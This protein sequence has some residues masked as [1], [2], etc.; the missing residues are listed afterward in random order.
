MI[1]R[2]DRFVWYELATTDR[3]AAKAFYCQVMDWGSCEM[4]VPISYTLFTVEEVPVCGLMDLSMS[5][6]EKGAKPRWLGFIGV[7]DVDASVD[8]IRRLGGSVLVPPTEVVNQ[9]HFAVVADPQM[10]NFA[11]VAWPKRQQ[12]EAGPRAQ[13]R[14]VWHE[15]LAGDSEK[16]L[17]FY[18]KLFGWQRAEARA[19]PRAVLSWTRHDRGHRHQAPQGR[20]SFLGLLLQCREHRVRG[21]AREAT[22]W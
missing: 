10:A 20:H 18:E 17:D 7:E 19:G 21:K 9:S 5:A 1:D 8:R 16:A 12:L 22:R 2:C 3:G 13:G 11:L 4:S 14:V 6:R 15:L